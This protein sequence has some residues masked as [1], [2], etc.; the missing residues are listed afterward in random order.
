MVRLQTAD[1]VLFDVL[2]PLVEDATL[3]D[4]VVLVAVGV[5]LEHLVVMLRAEKRG[6]ASAR[7]GFETA[8]IQRGVWGQ[9]IIRWFVRL[10]EGMEEQSREGYGVA[11]GSL[12]R[13][14]V[15][16]S[17]YSD[18]LLR[19]SMRV[20]GYGAAWA[21]YDGDRV[22]RAGW[23]A[24][25][26]DGGEGRHVRFLRGVFSEGLVDGV[27]ADAALRD[28][29][30][31]EHIYSALAPEP[32]VERGE[33]V[34]DVLDRIEQE[35]AAVRRKIA[36]EEHRTTGDTAGDTGGEADEARPRH[37]S[38]VVAAYRRCDRLLKGFAEVAGAVGGRKQN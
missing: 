33:E 37:Q 32:I 21:R 23:S 22:V 35:R 12:A 8:M 26:E 36:A 19:W 10:V 2:G 34:R 14:L 29:E 27:S 9:G 28:L 15:V 20:P 25:T 4:P 17:A 6:V 18:E 31:T 30:M 3:E 11:V 16:T 38:P 24:L 13:A 7:R 1:A 5:C